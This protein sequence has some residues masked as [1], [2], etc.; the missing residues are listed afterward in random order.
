MQSSRVPYL[1]KRGIYMEEL[2]VNKLLLRLKVF[3]YRLL[4]L[5]LTIKL[6]EAGEREAVKNI[7]FIT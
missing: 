2:H 5:T 1:K 3:I 6:M 4:D 7:W